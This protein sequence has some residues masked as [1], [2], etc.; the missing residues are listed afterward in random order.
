MKNQDLAAFVIDQLARERGRDEILVA[1]C[2]MGGMRWEEARRFVDGVEAA[3]AH[4][5]ASRRRPLYAMV[6]VLNLVVGILSV[7]FFT[8]ALVLFP[9]GIIIIRLSPAW[10][11][12]LIVTGAGMALGGL[13]GLREMMRPSQGMR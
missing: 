9:F 3:Y 11:P 7:G 10:Y 8:P 5:I 13:R 4:E 12:I 2:E 1:V 6:S